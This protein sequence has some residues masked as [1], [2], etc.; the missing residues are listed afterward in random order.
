[1]KPMVRNLPDKVKRFASLAYVG[2]RLKIFP[3]ASDLTG[4]VDFALGNYALECLQ[5]RAE[6]LEFSRMVSDLRPRALLEIGTFRGGTLFVFSKLAAEDATIISLDYWRYTPVYSPVFH[7]FCRKS[8]KLHVVR[9]DSRDPAH[10]SRI[11]SH[12]PNGTLDLLFIDGNHAYEMVKSDFELYS[13]LVR[14]GGMIAFHD[15]IT[16]HPGCNVP[17]FWTEIKDRHRHLEIVEDRKR[18][19]GGIGVLFW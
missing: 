1:M 13:P 2:A 19:W 7:S 17:Q 8:Q 6:L 10:F 3:A 16:R 14:P 11:K 5:H 9:G 12:L 4:I 15:I 18:D